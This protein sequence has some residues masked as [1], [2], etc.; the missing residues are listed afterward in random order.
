MRAVKE[1]VGEAHGSWVEGGLLTHSY[2]LAMPRAAPHSAQP[3]HN[4][5][6]PQIWVL[7][8]RGELGKQAMEALD[9]P[10]H[11]SEVYAL[12]W[13]PEDAPPFRA[14]PPGG[15]LPI[16]TGRSL[17]YLRGRLLRNLHPATRN[18]A[19]AVSSQSLHSPAT[20]HRHTC[21]PAPH[22]GSPRPPP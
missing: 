11:L 8:Q 14:S 2:A 22:P 15:K 1:E 6:N 10:N 16:H 12:L 17:L 3:T 18:S 9:C 21:R 20:L 5:H 19:L 4:P 7:S 13:A